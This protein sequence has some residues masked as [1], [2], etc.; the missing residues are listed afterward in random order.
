MGDFLGERLTSHVQF[1]HDHF[2]FRG[3]VRPCLS[4]A[5]FALLSRFLQTFLALSKDLL[6]LR[7]PVT[8]EL[9]PH[10][11]ERRLVL[12]PSRLRQRSLFSRFLQRSGC[13]RLPFAQNLDEPFEKKT[14]KNDQEEE[15]E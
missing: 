11:L 9:L 7:L 1:R 12:P 8:V 6:S 2:D 10:G 5:R 13:P 15:N 14:V 4:Q 3:E